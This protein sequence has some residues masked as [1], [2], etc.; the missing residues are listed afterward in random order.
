MPD[1][2]AGHA[3]AEQQ[4]VQQQLLGKRAVRLARAKARTA[5]SNSAHTA[6]TAL[7][8][9]DSA[10]DQTAHSKDLDADAEFL[11]D[12]WDSDKEE[13]GPKRKAAPLTRCKTRVQPAL[14]SRVSVQ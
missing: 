13:S 14:N 3:A 1:W 9:P 10:A 5:K 12:P 4:Q 7:K 2:M 6:A 11:L 8:S